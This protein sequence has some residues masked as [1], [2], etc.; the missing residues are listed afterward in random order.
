MM[1]HVRLSTLNGP[2]SEA[3]SAARTWQAGRSEFQLVNV[4][5]RRTPHAKGYGWCPSMLVNGDDDFEGDQHA[6]M[7]ANNNASVSNSHRENVSNQLLDCREVPVVLSEKKL[8]CNLR[9][10]QEP[11]TRHKARVTG[12]FACR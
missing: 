1:L 6:H 7:C 8:G 2:K 12:L 10:D 11:G 4:H 3:H 5:V 9:S